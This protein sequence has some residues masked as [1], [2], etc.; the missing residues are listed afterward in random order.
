MA[1]SEAN[2]KKLPY[3]TAG[4]WATLKARFQQKLPPTVT[5]SY[6]RTVLSYDTDK[7]AQNLI[8]QLRRIGLIDDEGAPT[9]LAKSF[10]LDSDY[11]EAAATI[12]ESVYPEEMR[13]LFEGPDVEVG[14]VTKWIMRY[15]D[16]GEA[17]AAMQARFYASLVSGKLPTTERAPRQSKAKASADTSAKAEK[18]ALKRKPATTVA[19]EKSEAFPVDEHVKPPAKPGLHLDI[20]IHIDANADLEH[21][22]AVF[23]SLAKHIYDKQQ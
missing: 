4:V 23:A 3:I 17:S 1:E 2:D 20:Q 9:P 12:V 21:I 22:D 11:L 15:T 5:V 19:P 14:D 6:L 16:G 13:S 7:A 10:R 8:P 18:P